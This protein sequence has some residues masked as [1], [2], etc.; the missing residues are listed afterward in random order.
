MN[1]RI[2]VGLAGLGMALVGVVGAGQ[3]FAAT[4]PL[5]IVAFTT[6]VAHATVDWVGPQNGN[7]TFTTNEGQGGNCAYIGVNT[8]P[9]IEGGAN[10]SGCS[11][12]SAGTFVNIV[13]GT[14]VVSG[15]PGSTNIYENDTDKYTTPAG[16]TIVFAGGIGVLV[17]TGVQ[18]SDGGSGV[19]AGVVDIAPSPLPPSPPT[20]T[21]CTNGFTVAA[22]L[23]TNA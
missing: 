16:Y 22:V 10:L 23:A 6:G 5:D 12:D 18:S 19:A 1:T 13:C 17:S 4:S 3:A 11:A 9:G 8:T 2:K 20:Q 21:V 14:G 7:Y 15:T